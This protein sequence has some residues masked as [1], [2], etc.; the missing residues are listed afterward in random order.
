[1]VELNDSWEY[2]ILEL[3]IFNLD[4]KLSYYYNFIKHNLNKIDGD[5]LEVGVFQG[6]S[7]L[8]TALLLKKLKSNKKV[9]GFDSFSGFPQFFTKR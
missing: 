6:R 4:I 5:I 1:M 9:Y 2:D 8:A 7:L 3:I